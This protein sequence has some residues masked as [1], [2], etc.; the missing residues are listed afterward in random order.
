MKCEELRDQY[1]L[2]AMGAASDPERGEIQEHLDRGCEVCTAGVKRAR[3]LVAR[4]GAAAPPAAPSPHLRRRILASVGSGK[5]GYG[6]APWLAFAASLFMV[7]ALYFGSRQRSAEEEIAAL[8]VQMREQSVQ[9]TRLNEAMAI[10]NSPNTR[11]AAFGTGAKGKVFVNPAGGVLLM[12]SN[13]W[14]APPGKAYEMWI[15]PKGGK[16]APAGMFQSNPDGTAMH[17]QTGTVAAD[18]T[19]AVTLENETGAAQ[20]TS[21]PLIVAQ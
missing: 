15:I 20:P 21:P 16:P 13:L 17:V 5:R 14:P 12:A 8:R 6:L 10:M 2:Y 3:L 9:L 18:V 19:V 1:E 11:E 4:L 7:A